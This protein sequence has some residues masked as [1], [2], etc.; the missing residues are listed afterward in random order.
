MSIKH[1]IIA[2]IGSVHD[3]SFG[4]AC[5]LVEAAAAC[6]ADV[7]KFQTHIA[8]AE[9]L[10]DAPSP[11][12]FKGEPRLDYFKRT[13]FTMEQWIK[14][15]EVCR[16]EDVKFLSSPFS[17]E[18]VDLLEEIGIDTYKIPSGEV[19]NIPLLTYVAKTGKPV[20]VSSGMSNWKE[21]DEAV[22][23][24]SSGGPL[25]VM[26]CTSAYPCPPEKVGLNIIREMIGRWNLP[27]GYSD[28]TLGDAAS[29]AAAALGATFIEKHF[30]FS[31][32]MYGSDAANSMEPAD[33]KRFCNGLKDI[34]KM[35]ES[36]VNKNDLSDLTDMKRIFEK[37]IVTNKPLSSG[38]V[39]TARDLAYKKPGDGIPASQWM[40][41]IGRKV[42]REIPMN[43]KLRPED[44]C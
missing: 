19:S 23:V 11:A 9:T 44:L 37:S 32:L 33:F 8:D 28:H 40:E 41:I 20:I 4:N 7:V 17:L 25:S 12:Y 1:E 35:L 18:A 21:L 24:L 22:N 43:Y 5:K 31:K 15:K 2:E 36:P 38:D 10:A 14:I 42:N 3:G 26:Q 13:A 16:S 29:F 39:I 34:W 30:T 6:G 27:I